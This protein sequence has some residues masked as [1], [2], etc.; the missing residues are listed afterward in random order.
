[1]TATIQDDNTNKTLLVNPTT[2][3]RFYRLHK[4]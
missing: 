2:G 1:V 4:P 3:N